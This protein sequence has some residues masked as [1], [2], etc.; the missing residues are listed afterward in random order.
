MKSFKEY[1]SEETMP[2]ALADKEFVGVE[3][4]AVRDNI[5][6]LIKGVTAKPFVTPYIALERVRKVL[7]YF[8]ISLPANNFMQ[9]DYGYNIFNINQFGAKFGQTNDGNVVVKEDSPY[10]VYFEYQ[11]SDE[12]LYDVFCEL[13]TD[14][15]LEEILSDYDAESEDNEE[16]EEEYSANAQQNYEINKDEH[17]GL[18]EE[19]QLKKGRPSQR[20]PLEGHPYHKKTDAELL[21]ISKD[22]HKAAEAMKG[23]NTEAENKYADQANDAATV[24]YFRKRNGMPNW[25]KKKYGHDTMKEENEPFD[26]PFVQKGKEKVDPGR[27]ASTIS[28]KATKKIKKIV[29]KKK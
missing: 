2:Q 13:V 25:Y 3:S 27:R 19:T 8:H 29:R 23:H 15:E 18:K 20:H 1:L 6:N 12:G 26:P 21:Y 17:E 22:A 5:N 24:R 7:A 10:S 4:E 14:D 28:A 11:A 9:G 16:N